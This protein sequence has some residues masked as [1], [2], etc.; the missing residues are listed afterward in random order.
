MNRILKSFILKKNK[1]L[2]NAQAE[3]NYNDKAFGSAFCDLSIIISEIN[4]FLHTYEFSTQKKEV[5]F[6][7][8]HMTKLYS[9]YW[10]Y[11]ELY[12]LYLRKP[13]HPDQFQSYFIESGKE[14]NKYKEKYFFE[15]AKYCSTLYTYD[16]D[17]YKKNI[18]ITKE[19][20]IIYK[21]MD[22]DHPHLIPSYMIALDK[23][24]SFLQNKVVTT[25]LPSTNITSINWQ[26]S[27]TDLTILVYGLSLTNC[28][29]DKKVSIQTIATILS[30]SFN[31]DLGNN[32]SKTISEVKQRKSLQKTI[33][34]EMQ[35]KFEEFCNNQ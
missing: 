33:L 5:A 10:F 21:F 22:K 14:Y 18:W 2:E 20:N 15:Y 35:A 17:I 23:L 24:T 4:Q 34:T 11:G 32:I 13:F 12:K 19:K 30:K 28:F 27:K 3:K 26:K 9:E 8:N 7:K 25:A 16:T 29:G 1:V 6:F 31:I